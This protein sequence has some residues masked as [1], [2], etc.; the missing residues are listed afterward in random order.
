M[1]NKRQKLQKELEELLGSK[2]VYFQPTISTKLKYPCVIY[3]QSRPYTYRA[4]NKL[5]LYTDCYDLTVIS[6]DPL[7]D[8]PERILRHFQMCSQDRFFVSDNLNH[9]ALT[10]YY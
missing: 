5:Y 9:W 1:L 2:N 10:L 3:Q 7:F 4:D 6:K 8:L